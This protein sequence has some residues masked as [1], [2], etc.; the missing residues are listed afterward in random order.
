MIILRNAV[1]RPITILRIAANYQLQITN[2]TVNSITAKRADLASLA[3]QL[4][5]LSPARRVQS[6]SQRVDELSRRMQT[7]LIHEIQLQSSRIK[8]LA[9]RLEA[10]S[11]L[12]VLA[13]GY[14]V[15]TRKDDGRVVARMAQAKPGQSIRIRVADGQFDAE[16][17]ESDR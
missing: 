12:A 17:S 1:R 11:P 8:G 4:R 10:L 5:Y 2:H 3:S 9:R 13:R 15:V 7:S 16:V 14:A 6:E